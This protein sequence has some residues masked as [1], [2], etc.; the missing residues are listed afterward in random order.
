M[1]QQVPQDAGGA[2][3][4][5]M[6]SGP[7]WEHPSFPEAVADVQAPMAAADSSGIKSCA[8]GIEAM[9]ASLQLLVAGMS[10]L[11]QE[12]RGTPS[13]VRE[14]CTAF[15][16]A[17]ELATSVPAAG[18]PA[19]AEKF[20]SFLR[21]LLTRVHNL[22]PGGTMICPAG[23]C[24]PAAPTEGGPPESKIEG[25]AI[26]VVLHR[27]HENKYA[28]AV[29]NCGEGA[30]YHVVGPDPINS[31]ELLRS[32]SFA[33][34]DIDKAVIADSSFWFA[35]LRPLIFPDAVNGPE[36]LYEVL[37]PYLNRKPLLCNRLDTG[38]SVWQS[39]PQAGD[40][41]HFHAAIEAMRHTLCWCGLEPLQVRRPRSFSWRL[42]V[43]P[44]SDVLLGRLITLCSCCGQHFC[45]WRV[46]T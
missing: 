35:L 9:C 44:L 30:E 12:S 23:W 20:V 42:L 37:L 13:A 16:S 21:V 41:S 46:T 17:V 19:A 34:E 7:I 39:F 14:T 1:L 15:T 6:S 4:M 45:R 33:L 40:H 29:C 10:R 24:R 32:Q 31:G 2:F 8:P 25:H 36:V 28:L 11:C 38:D 26:L 43:L 18:G 3:S 27:S 5:G 22:I